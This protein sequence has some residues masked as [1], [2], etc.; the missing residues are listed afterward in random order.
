MK[1]ISSRSRPISKQSNLNGYGIDDTEAET[2]DNKIT[3]ESK[4]QK[5][6]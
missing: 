6:Q 2:T 4:L 3:N 1:E 5:E